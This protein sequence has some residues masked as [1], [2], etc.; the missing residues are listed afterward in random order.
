M[1]KDSKQSQQLESHILKFDQITI[2]K[3]GSFVVRIGQN[4]LFLHPNLLAA[5][6]TNS[7]K[8]AA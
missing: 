7:K 6:K 1:K 8:R 5:V 4:V 2:A 3:N